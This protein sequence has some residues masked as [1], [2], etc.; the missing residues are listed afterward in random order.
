VEEA[1]PKRIWLSCTRDEFRRLRPF[2]RKEFLRAEGP[3]AGYDPDDILVLPYVVS[4]IG[5]MP[6]DQEHRSI[7]PGDLA[8]RRGSRVEA[9]NGPVGTVNEFVVD[10]ADN[11]ITHLVLRKGH[12]WGQRDVA[13]PVSEIECVRENVVYL[14]LN[15][16]RIGVMP[17]VP[18]LRKWT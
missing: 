2:I 6:G 18:V 3:F 13:I 1:A 16:L 8:V 15:K 12:P 14:R 7:P 4:E 17:Q 9:I 10:S 11:G 5:S